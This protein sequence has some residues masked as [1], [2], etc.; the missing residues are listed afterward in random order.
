V[1]EDEENDG[2]GSIKDFR[3]KMWST[4][5]N[6]DADAWVPYSWKERDVSCNVD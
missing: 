1:I 3:N 2:S 5:A 4:A 6:E